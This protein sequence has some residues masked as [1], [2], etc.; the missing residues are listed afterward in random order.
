MFDIVRIV[1]VLAV[2]LGV[3]TW[4]FTFFMMCL[5]FNNFQRYILAGC[6]LLVSAL[7]GLSYLVTQS[8][9]CNN[10]G[11]NPSCSIDQG[12]L[13]A[14]GGAIFWAVS[15]LIAGCFV[16]PARRKKR[17]SSKAMKKRKLAMHKQQLE[18]LEALE[19]REVERQKAAQQLPPPEQPLVVVGRAPQKSY[20]SKTHNQRRNSSNTGQASS[21][22]ISRNRSSS[23]SSERQR[24]QRSVSGSSNSSPNS[25]QSTSTPHSHRLSTQ[26]SINSQFNQGSN[27]RQL[28][29]MTETT[30]NNPMG[31]TVVPQNVTKPD[32]PVRPK[33]SRMVQHP[34]DS[35]ELDV[36][37]IDDGGLEVY[38][39]AALDKIDSLIDEDEQEN[40]LYHI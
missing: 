31:V 20:N 12:S 6:C 5:S 36:D 13:V 22:Q 40:N 37:R 35:T 3:S 32:P 10:V 4:I 16:E 11:D 28:S 25:S 27:R 15:A 38:I 14:I 34:Y 2:L 23:S 33:H 17:T 39:S 21:K 19:R 30:S 1:G 29:A 26:L 18:L 7:T 24:R 9:L 8:G